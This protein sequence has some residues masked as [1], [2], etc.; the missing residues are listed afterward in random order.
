MPNKFNSIV[1]TS[2]SYLAGSEKEPEVKTDVEETGAKIK[3]EETEP[4]LK[5]EE[6]P[7]KFV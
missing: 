4:E 6:V 7:R 1:K 3:S 5:T 2:T